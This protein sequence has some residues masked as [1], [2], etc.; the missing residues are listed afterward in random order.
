MHLSCLITS[1]N[2]LGNAGS[3]KIVSKW[4]YEIA[5]EESQ[6]GSI[7]CELGKYYKN[8]VYLVFVY[9]DNTAARDGLMEPVVLYRQCPIQR[10]NGKRTQGIWRYI[11]E[12]KIITKLRLSPLKHYFMSW[13]DQNP[14]VVSAVEPMTF[15]RKL[16]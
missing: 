5:P 12:F 10:A 3:N 6:Y 2:E 8:G 1:N 9:A 16:V 7:K 13:K 14:I 11:Y 15:F 4:Y